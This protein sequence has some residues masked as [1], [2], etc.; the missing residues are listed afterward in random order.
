MLLGSDE[1]TLLSTS[2]LIEIYKLTLCEQAVEVGSVWVD[3]VW[4]RWQ[5]FVSNHS[6]EINCKPACTHVR[7]Y[8][9]RI[10]IY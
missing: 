7:I 2:T 5:T 9:T 6:F 4:K 3:R 1:T 10:Y 8:I